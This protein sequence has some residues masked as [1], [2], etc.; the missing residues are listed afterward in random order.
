[1]A[2]IKYLATWTLKDQQHFKIPH[3][4]LLLK[5][6]KIYRPGIGKFLLHLDAWEKNH[7]ETRELEITMEVRYRGRTLDQNALS[8]SLYEIEVNEQNAGMLGTKS[9]MVNTMELYLADLDQWGEREYIKT[10]AR[11]VSRHMGHYRSVWIK[12]GEKW[13][14]AWERQG[15]QL[16]SILPPEDLVELQVVRG[17]SLYDT[18]EMARHID[19]Q[20]NRLAT[21]DIGVTAPGE[22]EGY[23]EKWKGYLKENKIGYQPKELMK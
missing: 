6:D 10:A 16:L 13:V 9:Q 12:Q 21:M 20:F 15:R 3:G 7:D 18:V 22:I 11:N 8:W 1:M 23:W 5:Y 2:K 19:G 14:T 4:Y 17:T